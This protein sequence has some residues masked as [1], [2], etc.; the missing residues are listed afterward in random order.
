MNLMT[1]LKASFLQFLFVMFRKNM[2]STRIFL[3]ATAAADAVVLLRTFNWKHNKFYCTSAYFHNFISPS[4]QTQPPCWLHDCAASIRWCIRSTII[5]NRSN[6]KI[7][8]FPFRRIY[9]VLGHNSVVNFGRRKHDNCIVIHFWF[10]VVKGE[11]VS[12][13]TAYSKYNKHLTEFKLF[14]SEKKKYYVA[15]Q[16]GF[17]SC[18]FI[19]K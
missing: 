18:C 9:W 17:F 10:V 5:F 15:L 4:I 19:K 13:F 11:N 6:C 7:S 3:A 14:F 2:Y 1:D 12:Q 16:L 8:S